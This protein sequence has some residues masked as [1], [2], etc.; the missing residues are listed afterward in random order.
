MSE[1]N[2]ERRSWRRFALPA[3]VVL[4]LF[5]VAVIGGHIWH[6]RTRV[7]VTGGPLAR[8]LAHAEAAL[9]APEAAKFG[10]VIRRDIPHYKEAAQQL[11]EA[12]EQLDRQI[13]AEQFDPEAAR[14]AL[15]TWGIAWNRFLNDFGP[16]LVEALA[17]ISPQSRRKLVSERRAER[18]RAPLP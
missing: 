8:A 14:R 4:N 13:L 11:G 16:T 18:A 1:I 9:P 6:V 2:K 3:S 5:L 12:R 17:D 7:V 10:G 15:T